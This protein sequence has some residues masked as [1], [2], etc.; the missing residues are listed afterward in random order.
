VDS[1]L[2]AAALAV[3]AA[4]VTTL[5]NT[6]GRAALERRAIRQ[7]IEIAKDIRDGVV[8]RQL[9]KETEN[10]IALYVFRRVGP[11]RGPGFHR[12]MFA[13]VI[14]IYGVVAGLGQV[15]DLGPAW[16]E[17]ITRT[18]FLSAV[19]I[20]GLVAALWA[21]DAW[22]DH[23]AGARREDLAAAMRRLSE[24]DSSDRV[25]SPDETPAPD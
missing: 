16:L 13:A 21:S 8:R 3:V 7:E 23:R 11:G 18:V 1:T 25:G 2:G 10:R 12:A 24:L 20:L 9:S 4:V 14:A 5:W 19:V 15:L 17:F 6:G 22:R